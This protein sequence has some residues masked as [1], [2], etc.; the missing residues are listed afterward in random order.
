MMLQQD[1]PD[2][3]I[4]ATQEQHSVREFVELAFG[5]CGIELDW[6]GSGVDE[7]G[8][9]KSTGKVLIDVN[10]K[11]FRPTE[12]DNLMGDFTKARTQLGWSPKTS[13]KELVKMMVE[14]DLELAGLKRSSIL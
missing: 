4:L 12:V 13:F 9:D 10:P 5:Y 7:R 3:Y 14:H 1:E 6:Q 2:D 11:Y 8:I